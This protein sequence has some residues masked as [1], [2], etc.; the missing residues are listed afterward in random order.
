LGKSQQWFEEYVGAYAQQFLGGAILG[1]AHGL[2]RGFADKV[3]FNLVPL[4]WNPSSSGVTS[5]PIRCNG[6]R[7]G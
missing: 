5:D 4:I 1:R 3:D 2:A 7:S 6:R